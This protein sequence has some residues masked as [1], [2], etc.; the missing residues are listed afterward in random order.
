M[1]KTE[2]ITLPRETL[3]D[4]N[5]KQ[6]VGG[7]DATLTITRPPVENRSLLLATAQI[8][9]GG[10]FEK[11]GTELKARFL[12]FTIAAVIAVLAATP[13]M[14]LPPMEEPPPPD[15]DPAPTDY[16]PLTGIGCI[17]GIV[18]V[19]PAC[20][21]CVTVVGCIA[22]AGV[23]SATVS[24]CL[25]YSDNCISTNAREGDLC[26]LS[27][28]CETG[29]MH[30][31]NNHCMANPGAE[32]QRC[33]TDRDCQAG[34]TCLL[35][36]VG[37]EGGK[38]WQLR[39]AGEL[40]SASAECKVGNICDP[41]THSCRT[42]GCGEVIG[43]PLNTQNCPCTINSVYPAPRG[44]CLNGFRCDGG[45]CT[46]VTVNVCACDGT[47]P[48]GTCTSCQPP[49]VGNGPSPP[50]VFPY[51]PTCYN[52]YDARTYYTCATYGDQTSCG[53]AEIEYILTDSFCL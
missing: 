28:R 33:S 47:D 4:L 15:L 51:S 30:C 11:R 21:A 2:K 35:D 24:A 19:E 48:L 44:D 41:S 46:Q 3:R 40:C 16:C 38:C 53:N 17:A 13:C 52:F 37:I 22:C 6:V 10:R 29:G 43:Q 32:L 8:P 5:L 39:N 31:V 26:Q 1:K 9:S 23:L 36:G 27:N 34:L 18:A 49:P 20:A 14:A 45:R 25:N 12:R 50:V 42:P 7:D